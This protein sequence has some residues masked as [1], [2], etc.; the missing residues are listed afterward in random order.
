MVNDLH[1]YSALSSPQRPQGSLHYTLQS[2]ILPFVH[3][4]TVVSYN[5]ATAALGQTDRNEAAIQ[6]ALP[7]PLTQR[8]RQ[9]EWGFE[10]AIHQLQDEPLPVSPPLPHGSMMVW[11]VLL[12]QDLDDFLTSMEP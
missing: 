12:P 7:S 4:F 8:L 1:L 11:A 9:T 3:N 2:V 5:V 6:S 10:P